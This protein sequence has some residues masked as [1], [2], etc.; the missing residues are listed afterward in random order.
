[1]TRVLVIEDHPL[2]AEGLKLGLES[3]GLDVRSSDG[4]P[5][6]LSALLAEYPA[7]VVLLDL[8]LADGRSGMDLIP[9]LRAPSRTLIVLTSETDPVIL[10]RALEAGADAVLAKTDPFDQLVRQ[11]ITIPGSRSAEAAN[12]RH[13]LLQQARMIKQ[14]RERQLA[15]FRG[16]TRR[17]EEVLALLIDGVP[18]AGIAERSFV[19]LSTVRSQIRSILAKLGVGSQ[20]AAVAMAA[21]AGWAPGGR[22]P[23]HS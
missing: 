12:R 4:S 2:V 15:A 11:I 10:A 6:T 18:A 9:V 1:M 5:A 21:R 8:Y 20:L 7:E 22:P 16:L 19:S 3:E 17:E 23:A 13:Q 14:E